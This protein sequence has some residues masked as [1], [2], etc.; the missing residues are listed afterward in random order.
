MYV[1]RN[2]EGILSNVRNRDFIDFIGSNA[3]VENGE[4][5]LEDEICNTGV[6]VCVCLLTM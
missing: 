5:R 3:I 2:I 6:C 4:T 1:F